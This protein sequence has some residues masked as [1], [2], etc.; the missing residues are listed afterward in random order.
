MSRVARRPD[1]VDGKTF[2][3]I[4]R[5]KP[6]IAEPDNVRSCAVAVSGENGSASSSRLRALRRLVRPP[7]V[8]GLQ[9][10]ALFLAEA[11]TDE[12]LP[13]QSLDGEVVHAAAWQEISDDSPIGPLSPRYWGP[14]G[15]L[16][17]ELLTGLPQEDQGAETG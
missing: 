11:D 6:R 15:K 8:T 12:L 2:A 9:G 7:S 13:A 10:Y 4:D 17:R 16:F 14:I 1:L 3:G 5:R